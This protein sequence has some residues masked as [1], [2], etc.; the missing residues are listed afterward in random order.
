MTL[1]VH[2]DNGDFIIL[3]WL[4]IYKVVSEYAKSILACME[5]TLKEYKRIW[6][7]RQEFFAV[8]EEYADRHKIEPISANFRLKL[9]KIQILNPH[10]IH[11][12][13]GKN[14]SHATVPLK[15]F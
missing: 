9:K 14:P 1:S 8:Y 3:E 13:I 5:N 11:V 7:I 4:Y 15:D 12:R 6:K 10:S 2:G